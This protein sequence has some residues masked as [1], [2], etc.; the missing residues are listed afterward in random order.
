MRALET[1]LTLFGVALAT[2][3]ALV[4]PLVL[5]SLERGGKRTLPRSLTSW[6]PSSCL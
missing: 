4:V 6:W 5:R 2:A 1:T 3:S